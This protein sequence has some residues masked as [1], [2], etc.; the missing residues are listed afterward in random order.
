MED[1]EAPPHQSISPG[2]GPA[3]TNPKR[4]LSIVLASALVL[5]A[6]LFGT[7]VWVLRGLGTAPSP[8][9]PIERF[10]PAWESAVAKAGVETVFPDGPVDVAQVR[11]SGSRPLDA[12]FTPEEI[13]ALMGI[14]RFET[15]FRGEAVSASGV[16]AAFPAEGM[17]TLDLVVNARGRE[18]HA[19]IAGSAS[20]A[21]G[22]IASPGLTSLSV[23][24]LPATGRLREMAGEGLVIY[25]NRYLDSIP[26]ILIEEAHIVSGASRSRA[27]CQRRSSIPNR[28]LPEARGP[29]V[30]VPGFVYDGAAFRGSSTSDTR[31]RVPA[32]TGERAAPWVSALRLGGPDRCRVRG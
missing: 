5:L 31:D 22:E 3:R 8:Q 30:L 18:Y 10:R 2:G 9:Q 28:S 15:S 21:D 7:A 24:G 14:Y 6:G 19:Q 32:R 12:T 1:R 25:L 17:A 27:R 13:S 4:V 29:L 16:E 23:E 11:A 26:G 20:Y